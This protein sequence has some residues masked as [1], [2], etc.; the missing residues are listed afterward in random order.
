MPLR[1]MPIRRKL[2]VMLLVTSGAVLALTCAAFIG[3]QYAAYR[4][5]ARRTLQML[6]EVIAS[7]STAAVAFQDAPDETDVLAALHAEPHITMAA[8]YGANGRLFAHYP[9]DAPAATFPRHP[10]HAGLRFDRGLLLDD[11]PIRQGGD[12]RLGTLYLRWDL[13]SMHRA[14]ALYALVA[15]GLTAL[16]MLLAYLLGRS[17][18]RQISRPVQT[19]GRAALAVSESHDYTVRAPKLGNDELG[20]L[21]D[22][23]NHMLDR[24][25][26][27]IA[28]RKAAGAR[29][30]RQA[31]RLD[32]LNRI[33]R[34]VAERQDLR[35]I[36][37]VVIRHLEEDVPIDFGCICLYDPQEETLTVTSV[38]A[39]SRQ[40]A[41]ELAL[42][43]KAR[44]RVDRNGL[45]RCVRGELV[46]E[47]DIG[48]SR[49]P[50][51]ATLA[52]GGLRALV[53]APLRAE[54]QVFGV[55][56]AARR[57]PASFTSGDCEF[58]RQLSEHVALAAHQ[59][60]LYDA[61]QRAYEDLRQSQETVV[62][63]ERL[64]ALGQMASGVAHDINNA[65]SPIALYTDSLLEREPALSDRAR[66]Y[67][68]TIQTAIHD[69]ARTVSRM[70]EFYRP[71]EGQAALV[72]IDLD[73]LIG[74]VLELT[75]ARWRD[76]PQERGAVIELRTE[77]AD[78]PAVVMGAEN[79]IRDALTNLIF[80][81]AD[82]MPEGG[83]LTL[84]TTTEKR[85][86]GNPAPEAIERVCLEVC[87][88]GIG[89]SEET[90]RRCLEPFFTTKG[91]R[92]TGMGLA[93]VYGMAQRH[94]AELAIDSVPG[95]GTTVRILFPAA[96]RTA[97]ETGRQLALASPVQP[98]RVLIV[99]DDPLIIESLRE[100]LGGDRHAVTAAE[101]G[102]A[103]IEAFA[104]ALARGEP[105]DMVITD[106]GM[107]YV[108]GRRV[109][110]AIKAASP[111][112]PVILLT[113]WGQRITA[114]NQIPPHVDRVL[115]KPPRLRELRLA[116]TEL[117]RRA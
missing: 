5:S 4:A 117:A 47:P 80:N 105:F 72:R 48:G 114:D 66:A 37:Q 94:R 30:Q 1:N 68:T 90:R 103:G 43:E 64:R 54:S 36:F 86:S 50:F 71:Q 8:V 104:A 74:G 102:Q 19:L 24:L 18:Q 12:P 110:A 23:F 88:T 29:L 60:Q 57:E 65:I 96:R 93:M 51:P 16:A 27:D 108:D 89:M 10:Q 22:A 91:E 67:L 34:A 59:A 81:A 99:D 45:S 25:T 82:A 70:R 9:A 84:R 113:G 98:L 78:P 53:V 56:V 58:L 52:K 11:Q 13:S 112:T 95:E 63:Q 38:G 17:L 42:T 69:V 39:R 111:E 97:D 7:N 3:Y 6:G 79:E 55:L 14:I 85:T 49:F 77:L 21:T 107:P 100:T 26:S 33:T 87:D 15:A 35:S 92:G 62:Q 115:N 73:R 106:L 20:A 40:T 75:Q 2:M 32:L 83:T 44:V 46:Y 28:E 61:L 109:A 31:S 41:L 101:G 76:L 116:L